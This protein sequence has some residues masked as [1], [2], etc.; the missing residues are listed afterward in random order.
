MTDV[1][2]YIDHT[3]LVSNYT[4][5]N[6]V[7][8]SG[9]MTVVPLAQREAV[10]VTTIDNNVILVQEEIT[11]V[12]TYEITSIVAKSEYTGPKVYFSPTPPLGAHIN[13]IW[14]RTN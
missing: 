6:I 13:D 3:T 5:T 12:P 8:T 4:D 14:V 1:I 9:Y 7:V 11:V 2:P 10:V